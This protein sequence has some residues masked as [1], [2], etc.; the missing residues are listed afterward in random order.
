MGKNCP[1]CKQELV[2][3]DMGPKLTYWYCKKCK[4]ELGDLNE[5][6][7]SDEDLARMSTDFSGKPPGACF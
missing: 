1:G 3:V 5:L 7:L 2:Y 4:K 6:E